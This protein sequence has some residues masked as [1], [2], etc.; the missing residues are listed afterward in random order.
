ME[1]TLGSRI[2]ERLGEIAKIFPIFILL[3]ISVYML[4]SSARQAIDG[5]LLQTP[6]KELATNS[7]SQYP[8]FLDPDDVVVK[9]TV[10]NDSG[11]LTEG[12][13]IEVRKPGVLAQT[14]TESM[15]PMFGPGNMLVQEEVDGS[16]QLNTGDVVVYENS[17]GNLIIHQI[18]AEKDGCYILKGLNNSVPDGVCVT[19]D[20]IK[21][22]L[23]FVIPTK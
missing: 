4:N 11:V 7:Y 19:K 9:K 10:F 5:F 12:L 20:M 6:A 15:Q 1:E 21:Y 18:I 16:T 14:S 3:I 23:L 13:T 22:R 17:Q 8:S 2:R